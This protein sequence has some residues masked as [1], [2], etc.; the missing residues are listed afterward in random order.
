MRPC[1]NRYIAGGIHIK[2]VG[3]AEWIHRQDTVQKQKT[4][5]NHFGSN[6][7]NHQRQRLL[8]KERVAF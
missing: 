1:T 8:G 7:S 6:N 5:Q 4:K 2:Y 3:R